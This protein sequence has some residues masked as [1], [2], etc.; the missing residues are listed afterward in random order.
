MYGVIAGNFDLT[1]IALCWQI[2][3]VPGLVVSKILEV[4][5]Y[6]RDTTSPTEKAFEAMPLLVTFA[7]ALLIFATTSH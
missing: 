1:H 2:A 6:W 3:L 4:R 5:N 7:A